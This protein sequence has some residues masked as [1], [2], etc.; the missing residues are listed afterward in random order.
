VQA[1]W[2][3]D[4][5][6]TADE[7]IGRAI[8][9]HLANLRWRGKFE[10][11]LTLGGQSMTSECRQRS[12]RI[13]ELKTN[14]TAAS[15]RHIGVPSTTQLMSDYSLFG[16]MTGVMMWQHTSGVLHAMEWATLAGS[17]R[18]SVPRQP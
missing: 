9:A 11:T 10:E 7:R 14:A 12:S 5:S 4:G 17:R 13:D 1:R 16:G 6:I 8:G 3:L 15:I 18:P 2:L